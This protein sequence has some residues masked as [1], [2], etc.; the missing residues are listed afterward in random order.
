MENKRRGDDLV[1]IFFNIS[2]MLQ[3]VRMN[4]FF[5]ICQWADCL[6]SLMFTYDVGN[7]RPY[8]ADIGCPWIREFFSLE[9]ITCKTIQ[10]RMFAWLCINT[11]RQKEIE[12]KAQW[13]TAGVSFAIAHT[14]SFLNSGFL[15]RR[16]AD[17]M[18]VGA[19]DRIAFKCAR[20]LL[21]S[22]SYLSE[23]SVIA[24]A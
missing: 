22:F 16:I 5:K 19:W 11:L 8:R 3:H 1:N 13:T 20:T 21:L 12:I 23:R 15:L 6:S 18:L 4:T 10:S 2:S 17:T 7:S 24:M 9:D 14:C